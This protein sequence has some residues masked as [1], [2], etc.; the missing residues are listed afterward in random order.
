MIVLKTQDV[1]MSQATNAQIRN[2]ALMTQ[3][4]KE[5]LCSVIMDCVAS[6]S[7]ASIISQNVNA[8][9]G[10]KSAMHVVLMVVFVV[11]L[12]KLTR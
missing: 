2:F 11:Q 6:L 10:K 3:N 7:V 4:V 1:K 8:K 9:T 12:I 5:V